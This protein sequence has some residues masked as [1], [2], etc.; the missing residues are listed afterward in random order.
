MSQ[1]KQ[2]INDNQ[3]KIKYSV[4]KDVK[5]VQ[6]NENEKETNIGN[7]NKGKSIKV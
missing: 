2:R 4:M 5:Q 7:E 3:L 6:T 1:K